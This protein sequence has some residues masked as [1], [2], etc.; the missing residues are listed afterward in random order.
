MQLPAQQP[1]RTLMGIVGKPTAASTPGAL[2]YVVDE[3]PNYLVAF[4]HLGR[5]L[6]D[7]RDHRRA[8][9]VLERALALL[10]DDPHTLTEMGRTWFLLEDRAR[11]RE[12]FEKAL[13]INP[14]Y[15]PAWQYFLR[16][17][18]WTPGG[19]GPAW[20][21]R[22]EET[23]P[24]CYPIALVGLRAYPPE[25]TASVLRRLLDRHVPTLRADER[26]IALAVFRPEI[27]RA[28]RNRPGDEE[29]LSLLRRACELFPE[30]PLLAGN[31]GCCFIERG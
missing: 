30:S 15:L 18:G 1:E 14:H 12:S 4:Q 3:N 2:S 17:L 23:F 22:A 31:S 10:P 20:A 8:M 28:A 24:A 6:N 5:V 21:R 19:D 7:Q 9:T 13:R 16:M 11:A 26:P 27:L 29:V 25:Q